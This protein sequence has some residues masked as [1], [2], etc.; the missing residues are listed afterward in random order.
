LQIAVDIEF[1][2]RLKLKGLRTMGF[3]RGNEGKPLSPVGVG[4]SFVIGPNKASPRFVNIQRNHP[5]I[6]HQYNK[7]TDR[8]VGLLAGNPTRSVRQLLCDFSYPYGYGGMM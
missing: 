3:R 6:Y 8:F 1:A 2:L 7:S 4:M 5:S